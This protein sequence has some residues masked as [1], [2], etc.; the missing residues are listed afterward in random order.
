ML[1]GYM[2]G[3]RSGQADKRLGILS[4]YAWFSWPSESPYQRAYARSYRAGWNG[5]RVSMAT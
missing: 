5:R 4:R 1:N 3:V 2:D